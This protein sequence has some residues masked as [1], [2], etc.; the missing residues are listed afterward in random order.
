[1]ICLCSS[2]FDVRLARESDYAAFKKLLD[3]GKHPAFIGKSTMM[4]NASQGG[5]IFY[6]FA[7]QRVAVSLVNPRLGIL[8]ALNV[9]PAHRGHGL[10]AAIVRFL[11]PNFVRAIEDKAP[12][13]ERLGYRRIGKMKRG[14][15]LN[16]QVMARTALFDLAGNLRKAWGSDFCTA[17]APREPRA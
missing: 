6:E 4:R 14:I 17:N 12:W 13:F 15:S 10:G 16:T 7:G 8:L 11:I 5:A 2:R 3:A 9:H 1:M